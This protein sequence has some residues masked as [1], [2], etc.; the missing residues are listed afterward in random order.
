M[1]FGIQVD[2]DKNQITIP[3]EYSR[4]EPVDI[5]S[6]KFDNV[7]VFTKITNYEIGKMTIASIIDIIQFLGV[8]NNLKICK[9]SD[10]DKV[11]DKLIQVVNNN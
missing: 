7:V 4:I 8:E 11:Q 3:R 2:F 5:T 1:A 10:W 6:F 9:K